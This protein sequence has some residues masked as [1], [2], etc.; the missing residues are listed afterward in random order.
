MKIKEDTIERLFEKD[1]QLS[2]TISILENQT[3]NRMKLGKHSRFYLNI[4]DLWNIIEN[5]QLMKQMG[6][7]IGTNS[8]NEMTISFDRIN[9]KTTIREFVGVYINEIEKKFKSKIN[10]EIGNIVIT[11]PS[12][13]DKR[14]VQFI[15]PYFKS[16]TITNVEFMYESYSTML[17]FNSLQSA[18]KQY[19][20]KNVKIRTIIVHKEYLEIEVLQIEQMVGETI[21]KAKRLVKHVSDEYGEDN[22]ILVIHNMIINK[23]KSAAKKIYQKCIEIQ[24]TDD[25]MIISKKQINKAHIK[26][27][28][29]EIYELFTKK[30]EHIEYFSFKG[31]ELCDISEISNGRNTM[32]MIPIPVNALE[33]ER[34]EQLKQIIQEYC[35]KDNIKTEYVIIV[36]NIL[37]EDVLTFMKE[38][39][40]TESQVYQF[41]KDELG[42][43][44]CLRAVE[45]QSLFGS[46]VDIEEDIEIPKL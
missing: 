14:A 21:T 40:F 17:L 10:K 46:G 34:I 37:S 26:A 42:S 4:I 18:Y 6:I 7:T 29:K 41:G 15:A 25:E 16:K 28:S 35:T 8:Q 13:I 3:T 19:M 43:G 11:I 39:C 9:F 45:I 32:Q 12:H 23:I 33:K 36:G 22:D 30:K 27:K 44:A 2:N 1:E 5:Q 31:L 24:P 38:I 20:A